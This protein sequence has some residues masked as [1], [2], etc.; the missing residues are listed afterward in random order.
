MKKIRFIFGVLMAL[1]LVVG[2]I[3]SQSAR[4]TE[5]DDFSDAH[6]L[7]P[8]DEIACNGAS[9]DE[10][11][12]GDESND[13]FPPFEFGGQ[14][15]SNS[16]GGSFVGKYIFPLED[17]E[18]FQK[19]NRESEAATEPTVVINASPNEIQPG[20]T[21]AVTANLADFRDSGFSDDRAFALAFSVD[22]IPLGG[23]QAGGK[24]LPE[25]PTGSSCGGVTRTPL[26]DSDGDGMDD[27]WEEVHGLNPGDPSDAF[28]DPDN[29]SASQFF[30]NVD[31]ESL[32]ITPGTSCGLPGEMKNCDEYIWDTDPNRKDTDKDS[33]SDGE[34]T[35]GFGGSSLT[36]I[37]DREIGSS[38]VLRAYGVGLS[39]MQDASRERANIVKLD[40]TLKT[41][42]VTNGE[43]LKG[44]AT[45]ET[46]FTEPGEIA[47]IEAR[48]Q[49]TEAERDSFAYTYIVDGQE[50]QN[51]SPGRHR[52][53][54]PVD[55][56][57]TPGG[58][59]PY[60]IRAVNPATGQLAVLRGV[61]R[62]GEK[63]ILEPDPV[64]PT[65]GEA[66]TVHAT[67]PSGTD[68]QE[69]LFEW[70]INSKIDEEATGVGKTSISLSAPDTVGGE[71]TID[72]S[73]YGV[74]DSQ[75]VGQA[76]TVVSVGQPSVDLEI[77]PA[78]PVEGDQVTVLAR[79]EHFSMNFDSDGDSVEDATTL[80][81]EW[82]I[83]GR[84]LPIEET[85]AG[86]STATLPAELEGSV[87]TISVAVSSLGGRAE[88]AT[89]ELSF[90][91]GLE[92]TG[93]LSQVQRGG[94]NLVASVVSALP[95]TV[96]FVLAGTFGAIGLLG[97]LYW[98][99]LRRVL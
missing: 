91:T 40:A 39:H 60:E 30:T 17:D 9:E 35:I 15:Q 97:Y 74:S 2:L 34:E 49:G 6:A 32:E 19:F 87:H 14:G 31:G 38:L 51:P 62:V 78:E 83:D 21:V 29:D 11:D 98:M 56:E 67:L 33:I 95:N 90:T 80:R 1:V 28:G 64:E 96:R 70:K 41:L 89:A 20:T 66:F 16:G 92:G 44:E 65:A 61:V 55:P 48:F 59:I 36:F 69:Y 50:V 24:E 52:L 4:A 68:P 81:Y 18:V 75:L 12:T 53:E 73:L 94:R 82:T 57:A 27:T 58:Q 71:I 88:S 37:N 76:S 13:F 42:Y 8:Y 85:A 93:V 79:P 23:I 43:H 26:S 63:I 7:G 84:T 47:V 72:L 54:V 22:E 5:T 10:L 3:P 46:F 25:S 99:R 86:F 77:I 45:T